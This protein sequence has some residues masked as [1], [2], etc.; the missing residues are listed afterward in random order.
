MYVCTT[1]MKLTQHH[2]LLL[3]TSCL[4]LVDLTAKD[5]EG[6]DVRIAYIAMDDM[7]AD[8]GCRPLGLAVRDLWGK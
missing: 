8:D 7:T 1:V 2:H 5:D 3:H 4:F 6:N